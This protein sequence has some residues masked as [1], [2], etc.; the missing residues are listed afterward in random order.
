VHK[1]RPKSESMVSSPVRT[2]NG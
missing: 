1:R 2:F